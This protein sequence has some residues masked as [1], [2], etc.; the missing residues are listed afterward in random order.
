MAGVLHTQLAHALAA[1]LSV[2]LAACA[3][4]PHAQACAACVVAHQVLA[5][6]SADTILL[7]GLRAS[8]LP[9]YCAK[10]D[11]WAV[12]IL[13]HEALSGRTPFAHADP[14]L[15]SLRAQFSA[16]PPL[17]AGVSD[18]CA[19]FAARALAKRPAE[20]PSARELLGHAWVLMHTAPAELAP[21]AST[22]TPG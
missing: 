22:P 19:D 17:P 2:P 14:A 16:A 11:V 6:P 4:A 3:R 5:Q 13:L 8:Q 7:R 21:H 15:A 12:G 20:R 10:A 18:A 1:A 9:S